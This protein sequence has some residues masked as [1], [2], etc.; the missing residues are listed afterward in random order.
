MSEK[1]ELPGNSA[2]P[3][4]RKC[5]ECGKKFCVALIESWSYKDRGLLM[6]SW[7][8]VR[9]R[10]EKRRLKAESAAAKKRKTMS[11][12]QK[13]ELVRR[14]V[15]R[16]LTNEQISERTGISSQLVNYYRRKVESEG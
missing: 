3:F 16:G 9:R 8:C 11:A 2:W 4:E 1:D 10:E 5:P 7:G 15:F 14:L 12:A 6:C 13:E